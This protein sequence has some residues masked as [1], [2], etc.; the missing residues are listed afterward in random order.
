MDEYV[1]LRAT[2]NTGDVWGTCL[3][4]VDH[5]KGNPAEH[6]AYGW[7]K[8]EEVGR[9]QITGDVRYLEMVYEAQK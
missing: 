5:Y 8:A 4:S 3:V 2:W 7:E 1:V 9:I 6:F